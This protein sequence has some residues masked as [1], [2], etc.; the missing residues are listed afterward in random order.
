LFIGDRMM[1][2]YGSPDPAARQAGFMKLKAE[3]LDLLAEENPEKFARIKNDEI[4][5][6]DV[7]LEH[8]KMFRE[9]Q[10]ERR[11]TGEDAERIDREIKEDIENP[12]KAP[13]GVVKLRFGPYIWDILA[14]C[15]DKLLLRT[16]EPY[17]LGGEG[18]TGGRDRTY[19]YPNTSLAWRISN[20]SKAFSD[21]EIRQIADTL[22]SEPDEP[23]NVAKVFPLNPKEHNK[24]HFYPK[25]RN[26][27]RSAITISYHMDPVDGTGEREEDYSKA[28][29]YGK[30][31]YHDWGTKDC[32][33]ALWLNLLP[34]D[35]DAPVQPVVSLQLMERPEFSQRPED[36]VV[37]LAE[38]ALSR[39]PYAMYALGA[40][41][42]NGAGVSQDYAKAL[43]LYRR[44]AEEV[45]SAWICLGDMYA[46]G[47]G[48]AKDAGT[49]IRWYMLSI[50]DLIEY[51][52][53][54]YPEA[55]EELFTPEGTE[56]GIPLYRK[57][58]TESDRT[59][60][61]YRALMADIFAIG[62][63][64]D[65]DE[66]ARWYLA[67]INTER[68]VSWSIWR[69]PGPDELYRLALLYINQDVPVPTGERSAIQLLKEA[70]DNV[71]WD[72]EKV[73]S[74]LTGMTV[75]ESFKAIDKLEAKMKEID[76]IL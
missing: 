18:S 70:K 17:E 6:A 8:L 9:N 24:I 56:A 73:R 22:I 21:S 12:K 62:A 51:L 50:G 68:K 1:K 61:R 38:L 32:F 10:I 3:Y 27:L 26:I 35:G 30:V 13:E 45:Q 76:A 31:K 49:A 44:A 57:L 64:R 47:K 69:R 54:W 7:H 14:V 20:F 43:D 71:N 65:Y 4:F 40:C 23:D 15:G 16:A 41:Y 74:Y 72:L 42:E 55:P 25:S 58:L 60:Y 33:P 48:V 63:P 2:K 36:I 67:A 66:A 52:E 75:I 39:A 29:E 11:K 46:D 19:S 5:R 53:R 28:D 37:R 34:A 59:G